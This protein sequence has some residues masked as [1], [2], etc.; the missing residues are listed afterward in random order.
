VIG[1]VGSGIHGARFFVR[2]N[3]HLC[4]FDNNGF[5]LAPIMTPLTPAAP[6]VFGLTGY[7]PYD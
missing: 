4:A 5:S 6:G 2:S 3:E 1:S 7:R